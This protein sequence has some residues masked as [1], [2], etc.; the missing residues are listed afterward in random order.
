MMSDPVDQAYGMRTF[1]LR[2]PDGNELRVGS[3]AAVSR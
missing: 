1:A 2:D 3:P